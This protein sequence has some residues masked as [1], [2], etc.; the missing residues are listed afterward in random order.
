MNSWK[1]NRRCAYCESIE[2]K[3]YESCARSDGY[4]HAARETSGGEG[5]RVV[6]SN[7]HA[8]SKQHH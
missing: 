3:D 8:K 2:V 5:G 6:L 4:T 7:T 1:L